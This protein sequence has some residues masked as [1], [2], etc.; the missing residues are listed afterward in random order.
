M[1][2]DDTDPTRA[3]EI[4]A[5]RAWPAPRTAGHRGWLL[6]STPGVDRARSNSALTPPTG[7][8]QVRD[9]DAVI[10]W[11]ERHNDRARVMVSPLDRHPEVDAELARRGWGTQREVDVL[12][13]AL[14]AVSAPD[15]D[16]AAPR[17]RLLA[18]PDP[19]WRRAWATC[20][21]RSAG[22]IDAEA[23]T[24][25]A[26]LGPRAAFALAETAD[27]APAGVGIAVT[28][29]AWC[30][31][32]A[33]AAHPGV[34]RVGVGSAVLRTLAADARRRGAAGA[35]LQVLADNRAA[36]ALYRRHGFARL[37]GYRTREAPEPASPPTG[38][39]SPGSS[40]DA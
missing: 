33:M 38:S 18:A 15:A 27:G 10:A 13:G 23:D 29:G 37:Y 25:L 32:F 20:E 39:S 8:A 2:T 22:A 28:T 30:G 12:V 35:Y 24:I 21:G 7:P 36:Q 16:P 17:V 3:V 14:G 1:P 34:R 31:L 6:R 19:G 11:L 4:A 40:P 9:L 5:A 26:A